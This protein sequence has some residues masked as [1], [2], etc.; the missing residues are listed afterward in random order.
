A[1]RN[2]RPHAVDGLEGLGPGRLE[3]VGSPLEPLITCGHLLDEPIAQVDRGLLA[4]LRDPE[5]VEDPRQRPS[6]RLLD[7]LV[8]VLCALPTEAIQ[9]LE[10]LDREPVEVTAL[11]DHP[12]LKQLLEDL[13]AGTFDIHPA[14]PDEMREL[15]RHARRACL[16][17][18]VDADSSLVLDDGR[19]ADRA[20]RRHLE[21]RFIAR[22]LLDDRPDDLRD[23][24]A[25]L[26]D[27]HAVPEPNVLAP[28]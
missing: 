13:P 27:D 9:R 21:L 23:H 2:G 28:Y 3:E 4:D 24:V 5:H 20:R 7:R 11:A 19:G 15:L 17:R 10:V 1:G 26:L 18:A 14:T 6:A 25:G 8:Q 22:A 16:V 12:A